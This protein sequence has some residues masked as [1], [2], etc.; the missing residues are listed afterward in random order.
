MAYL[1]AIIQ[2]LSNTPQIYTPTTK[3]IFIKN[4]YFTKNTIA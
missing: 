1:K 4:I 3:S 2:I